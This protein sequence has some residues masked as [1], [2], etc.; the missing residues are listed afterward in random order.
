M[1]ATSI[2]ISGLEREREP[3]P[4]WVLLALVLSAGFHGGLFVFLAATHLPT[5]KP[6]KQVDMEI[7]E[8]KKKP[9]PKPPDPPKPPPP[10]PPKPKIVRVKLP[11]PP[12]EVPPPPQTPPPPNQPP[13]KP[14]APPPINIGI[15]LSS[16]TQSGGFAAPVGNTLYG[17]A[18]DKAPTPTASPGYEAPRATPKFVP[19]YAVTEAP[20]LLSDAEVKK[21]YPEQARK[22]GLEGQVTLKLKI[23]A[24][25]KVAMAKVLQGAGHGFDEA[26]IEGSKHL[27][28]KPATLNGE[29]VETE[30][31][32][33]MTF[34]L[35]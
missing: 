25:G 27:R 32:Y 1:S 3:L 35:D 31:T 9:P 14:A 12:K 10:E 22:D 6:N 24:A 7:V 4:L 5:P 34:L 20:S 2:D 21:F 15:S 19:S 18:P 28:F 16:T 23:D 29:P 11:P 26:A 30:I 33:T 8:V 13:P 17:Q